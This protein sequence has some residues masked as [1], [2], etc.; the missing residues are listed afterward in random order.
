MQMSYS[1]RRTS[2]YDNWVLFQAGLDGEGM[3]MKNLYRPTWL[4]INVVALAMLMRPRDVAAGVPNA[5]DLKLTKVIDITTVTGKMTALQE[6]STKTII[7][8]FHDPERFERVNRVFLGSSTQ[9]FEQVINASGIDDSDKWSFVIAAPRSRGFKNLEALVSYYKTEFTLSCT[10]EKVPALTQLSDAEAQAVLKKATF[11]T[12]ALVHVPVALARDEAGV[13]YYVD[14]LRNDLGGQGY[15]VYV[16]KRGALKL[17]PL[18]DVAIDSGGM[19]F[20]TKKGEFQL[21]LDTGS[22][23]T[24]TW[25]N[26]GKARTL[27][28]LDLFNESYLIHRELGIY[29]A[30]GTACDDQ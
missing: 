13:Y 5:A 15:R 21:T 7:L 9:L 17:M 24:A 14:R 8:L 11:R 1:S 18:R 4:L 27:K 12:S 22:S 6:P 28:V 23:V 25:N 26:K 29:S 30:F 20:A 16:G 2:A 10:T 19:V 3:A